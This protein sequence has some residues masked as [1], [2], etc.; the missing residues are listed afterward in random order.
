MKNL[1]T[2]ENNYSL[3]N[4]EHYKKE[5]DN[6]LT[7]I[8]NKISELILEYIKYIIENIK[9]KKNVFSKF[10]I[11]RGLDTIMHVFNY[12]LFYT[13]NIELTYFHC[14]KSFYFYVEF[15][16]QISDEEKMF[17]QLN[18]RD[19]ANYVYKKTIFEI[20]NEIKK[21][22]ESISE[23]TKLKLDIIN[24]YIEIYKTHIYKLINDDYTN[25]EHFVIIE[26]IFK[27]L[28]L[29]ND[30]SYINLYYKIT[31][32]LYY[33]LYNNDIFF[34][35]QLLIVKKFIKTPEL[36]VN[37]KEKILS[38]EFEEKITEI[39]NKFLTWFIN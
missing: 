5:L 22:N 7:Y 6:D 4:L 8:V 20:N 38:E 19:A 10:I 37:Y 33:K 12:I 23:K 28:N 32:D 15:V 39:P 36:F 35:I 1:S 27:K 29:L 16:G 17:L 25:N 11:I 26:T 24:K 3:H 9:L 30:K 21:N 13:K 34:N 31:E 2:K 18:S 14:Q